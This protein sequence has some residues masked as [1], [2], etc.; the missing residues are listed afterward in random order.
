MGHVRDRWMTAGANGRKVRNE[1]WGKGRRW[2]ARWV[3]ADGSE[4]VKACTTKDEA[5]Q[6]LARVAVGEVSP[7][8]AATSMLT[9]GEYAEEWRKQRLHHRPSTALAAEGTFRRILLPSL[10]HLRLDAVTRADVQAAV[11]QW[12]ERLAP[13]TVQVAYGYVASVYRHAVED[14]LVP[15]TPCVR[16]NLPAKPVE[17]VRPLT[18]QQVEIIASRVPAWY[19]AMVVVDAATGLRGGELRGLTEDRVTEGDVL[20]IDRQL[21]AIKDGQPVFG[22]P[23]SDAGVRT[24]AAG[25]VAAAALAKHRDRYPLGPEGL[26]FVNR[27]RSPISRGDMSEVWRSATRD[28]KLRPRSGWH[29]LRHFHASLLIAAGLSPRAVA[30]RLGHADVAETLRT[31]AHLWPSDQARAVAAA[32]SVLRGLS[33][34]R[35]LTVA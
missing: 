31:Y 14:K 15:F 33:R 4:R 27:G 30:D 25:E 7:R 19:R 12:S 21:V 18:V 5:E 34:D 24:V 11:V 2:Q 8:S 29:D 22:P 1:R 20:V 9:F 35:H 13:S 32:D 10:G 26:I 3:E 28:L 17:R 16:I 6:V 23:K